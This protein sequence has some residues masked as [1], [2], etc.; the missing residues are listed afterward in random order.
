MRLFRK[1]A[2]CLIGLLVTANGHPAL[3]ATSVQPAKTISLSQAQ[4]L[5]REHNYGIK[6]KQQ[7]IIRTEESRKQG[8]D[9]AD[10]LRV[11]Q[12]A[13]WVEDSD[14]KSALVNLQQQTNNLAIAN[15]KIELE[16]ESLDYAV[17]LQFDELRKTKSQ[18]LLLNEKMQ[19]ERGMANLSNVKLLYGLN[20]AFEA[21]KVQA[22]LK[23]L[24]AEAT[25]AEKSLE[26]AYIK[27]NHLMGIPDKER[28]EIAYE[29]VYAPLAERTPMVQTGSDP[30]LWILNKQLATDETRL[31]LYT[32]SDNILAR[33]ESYKG[34]EAKKKITD[35]AYW[36]T[37][38]RLTEAVKTRFYQLKQIEDQMGALEIAVTRAEKALQLAQL[39]YDAGL[40]RAIDVEAAKVAVATARQDHEVALLSHE[41]LVLSYRKPYLLPDYLSDE[42]AAAIGG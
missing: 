39:Q 17:R 30:Y 8:V 25:Q 34:R 7:N 4:Q 23:Q 1:Y 36:D 9:T 6:N 15:R 24:Q 28:Y 37:N 12:G 3:A 22:D 5:A 16:K 32:I 31:K 19:Y 35:N 13:S 40:L 18:L 29:V 20:S 38:D 33:D 14:A 2:I 41:T 26:K 10:A 21:D 42:Y 27:L 11:S